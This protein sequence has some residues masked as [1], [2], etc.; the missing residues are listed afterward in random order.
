MKRS[1]MVWVAAFALLAGGF[2]CSGGGEPP[3]GAQPSESEDALVAR[4]R[5]IHERVIT[6]D[7][8][9]DINANNFT[10]ERNYTQDL[11]NQV[12]LPK[13]V[14]GGLDAAFFIVYVGQNRGENAFTKE[15]YDNAYRQAIEK[16]DA[17]HRLT[18]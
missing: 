3:A 2:G 4:A 7:T 5:Q 17:I 15:G 13:M 12:N 1:I 9:A 10:T 8:H 14:E 11:G 18:E 6:L 16:F